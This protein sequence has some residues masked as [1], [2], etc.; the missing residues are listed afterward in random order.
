MLRRLLCGLGR[1]LA[2][3]ARAAHVSL[4]CEW[5]RRGGTAS[6][7]RRCAVR[8]ADGEAGELRLQ[9]RDR[10]LDALLVRAAVWERRV[11]SLPG[12]N[13]AGSHLARVLHR[14]RGGRSESVARELR[15]ALR[16]RQ[17]R[18]GAEA[19]VVRRPWAS[20]RPRLAAVDHVLSV[21]PASVCPSAV[22]TVPSTCCMPSAD[23]ELPSAWAVPLATPWIV[24][25][26]K[27]GER[28]VR[29]NP[30]RVGD[31][32]GEGVGRLRDAAADVSDHRVTH[33]LGIVLVYLRLQ[34]TQLRERSLEQLDLRLHGA[35]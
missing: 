35:T 31:A 26:A 6:A 15:S 14:A 18:V 9:P 8:G 24:R 32:V 25:S 22:P 3:I 16:E 17:R 33:G 1:A 21:R 13:E 4:R 30:R 29:E 23:V 2:V 34:R 11:Q 20:S 12:L 28:L 5:V 10:A 7:R 27:W 19:A